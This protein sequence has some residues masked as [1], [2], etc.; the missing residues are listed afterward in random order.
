MHLL[1]L[2]RTARWANAGGGKSICTC[3]G[4][5]RISCCISAVHVL[6]ISIFQLIHMLEGKTFP[7]A[8]PGLMPEV[9]NSVPVKHSV[10]V[11]VSPVK[12]LSKKRP[13]G[14]GYDGVGR[15]VR[16]GDGLRDA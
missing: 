16:I 12:L 1:R 13:R 9:S 3:A 10:P 8:K 5:T 4:E 2:K 11:H 7:R 14:Q 15:C 6:K